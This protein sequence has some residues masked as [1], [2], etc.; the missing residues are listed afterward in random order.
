ML[1]M[2]I[3]PARSIQGDIDLPGDKSISHR[4]AILAAMAVGTT[5][6]SNFSSGADCHTTITCLRSLGVDITVNDSAVTVEGVGKN[7]FRPATG[8]IDCGNSGTTMRLLAGLLAGQN[9]DSMLTGDE[10]LKK[11]PMLRVAD[12]L[13]GMGAGVRTIEGKP[14]VTITGRHPLNAIEYLQAVASAQIKSCILLAGLNSDGETCV[15]E[16]VPTRDHTERMLRW[17][18]VEVQIDKVGGISRITVSGDAILRSRDLT[19]PSDI[20]S[21]AFFMVAAACM[22]G[23][24]I[25]ISGVG[26]NPGR[27]AIFELL[28]DLDADVKLESFDEI[29]NEPVGTIRVR[30]GIDHSGSTVT[31]LINGSTIANIIDEIPILAVFATQIDGGLEVRDASELRVKETDRIA[32]IVKNLRLMGAAVEEFPDGF[33][34]ERSRLKGALLSSYGDH[35]IAMAFAIAG[36]LADGETEIRDAECADI[37]FPGFF[38]M[39][40]S[41][42]R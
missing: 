40:N 24:D 33:R 13:T 27:A 20:S 26:F 1:N 11:R 14:P 8:P 38:E 7:G 42:V 29:C 17:F 16:P 9:F 36:L 18:G 3:S 22:K 15:V 30:G 4:A 28:R 25:T 37:S 41:V 34:V 19:V 32:A 39:L 35:R 31:T 21:A 23:S 12:P 2:K 10:S 6:I 5:Q